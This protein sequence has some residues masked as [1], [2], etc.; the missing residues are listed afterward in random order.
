[1]IQNPVI[2]APASM[3][4]KTYTEVLD[5]M[6][7]WTD[8]Y[9]DHFQNEI[10]YGEQA[11]ICGMAGRYFSTGDTIKYPD[12]PMEYAPIDECVNVDD[13]DDKCDPNDDCDPTEGPIDENVPG[14]SNKHVVIQ[15]M[16]CFMAFTLTIIS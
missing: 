7:Q 8:E 3:A 1:M 4:N 5:T 14:T 6:I 2:T 16:L 13:P 12:I 15:L 10:R 9:R 11:S